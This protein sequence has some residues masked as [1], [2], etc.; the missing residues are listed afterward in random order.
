MFGHVDVDAV[1]AYGFALLHA[2]TSSV[3]RRIYISKRVCTMYG[4]M[5]AGKHTGV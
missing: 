2:L 3:N 5:Y 4:G 1:L